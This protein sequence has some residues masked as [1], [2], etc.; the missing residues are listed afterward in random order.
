MPSTSPVG[1]IHRTVGTGTSLYAAASR[2]ASNW[3]CSRYAGKTGTSSAAGATRA[4]NSPSRR[5]PFSVHEASRTRVSDDIPLAAM[6]VCRVTV[7]SAPSGSSVA[8]HSASTPG[9]FSAARLDRCI[10]KSAA[11]GWVT[12]EA[13]VERVLVSR[14]RVNFDGRL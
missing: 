6:P 12:A 3:S 7:G 10:E 11:G 13:L 4:T 1:S 8:S 5:S 2:M 14:I 9:M